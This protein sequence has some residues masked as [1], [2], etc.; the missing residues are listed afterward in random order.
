[1]FQSQNILSSWVIFHFIE[2]PKE[3][4][5]AWKN[6]LS[7]NMKYFSIPL[8]ART[9]FS[10]WR[11]YQWSRPRGFDLGEYLEAVSGNFISRILGAIMRIS[12]IIAGLLAEAFIFIVG[13]AVFL[14]WLILPA[15]LIFGLLF[16]LKIVL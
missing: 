2:A 12:L 16:G 11:N 8:L 5:K 7:F 9:L 4:L 1:M 10:Y 3:I 6:F 13:I 14:G 15:F